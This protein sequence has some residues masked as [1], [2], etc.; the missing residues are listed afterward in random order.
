MMYLRGHGASRP[1]RRVDELHHRVQLRF[2]R[3]ADGLGLE[4]GGGKRHS[5]CRI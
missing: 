1:V 3:R 4:G 5:S 2:S